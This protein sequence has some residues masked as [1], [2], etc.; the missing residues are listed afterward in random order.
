MTTRTAF[1][2]LFFGFLTPV[3][4]A[5]QFLVEEGVPK[6]VIV[7]SENPTRMQ[8]V[9]AEEFRTQIEKISGARLPIATKAADYADRVKIYIGSIAQ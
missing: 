7:I 2:F 6:A 4:S 3:F 8:R 5:D 1:L 9:A